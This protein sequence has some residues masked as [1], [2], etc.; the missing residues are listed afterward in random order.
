M[1][2]R[3]PPRSLAVCLC[4]VALL[5]APGAAQGGQDGPQVQC[6][7]E[8]S[9]ERSR[10]DVEVADLFDHDLLHLVRLGLEGR[11]ALEVA[12]Y[13]RRAFWFDRRLATESRLSRVVWSRARQGFVLDGEPLADPARL[14]LPSLV[15]RSEADGPHYVEVSV[16][17]EVVTAGS[18]VQVA[19]WLVRGQPGTATAP[20]ALGRSLLAQVAADLARSATARC[21]VH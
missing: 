20:S 5:P 9:G 17:L 1:R 10:V 15:L 12:L 13:R 7:A 2:G 18:L 3:G 16:R 8:R 4:A 21:A 19:R 11:I 14:V 6:R